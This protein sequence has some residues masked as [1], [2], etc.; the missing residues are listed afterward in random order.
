MPFEKG[1]GACNEGGE[2]LDDFTFAHD[3][4]LINIWFFILNRSTF[5]SGNIKM[6]FDYALTAKI[7]L[8]RPS[9]LNIGL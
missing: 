1:L 9:R 7:S 2:S 5:C 8:I 6:Q 3:L 4:V